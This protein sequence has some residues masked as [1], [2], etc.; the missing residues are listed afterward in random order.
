VRK[1]S[2]KEGCFK[3]RPKALVH[4]SIEPQLAASTSCWLENEAAVLSTQQQPDK[5]N[6]QPVYE[7]TGN[8]KCLKLPNLEVI[9]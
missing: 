9:S 6:Y 8:S 3:E 5:Q 7:R 2:I 4:S 1:P